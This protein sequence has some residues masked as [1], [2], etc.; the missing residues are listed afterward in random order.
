MQLSAKLSIFF[1]VKKSLLQ[2]FLSHICTPRFYE[3]KVEQWKKFLFW[4][5]L[6]VVLRK[7]HEENK[8]QIF[9]INEKFIKCNFLLDCTWGLVRIN[10]ICYSTGQTWILC[11]ICFQKLQR[12][13]FQGQ[14]ENIW[15][16]IIFL[17]YFCTLLCLSP[18]SITVKVDCNFSSLW[19]IS[20][21]RNFTTIQR[22]FFLFF[23][24]SKDKKKNQTM[25]E[26]DTQNLMLNQI[27][28]CS[29]NTTTSGRRK[30]ISI[31]DGQFYVG[32][33]RKLNRE[34]DKQKHNLKDR[35]WLVF[36]S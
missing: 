29:K 2:R 13:K 33:R 5:D 9:F 35:F 1:F 15:L 16:A 34:A 30:R 36:L 26:T 24:A 18:A 25:N 11:L 22:R 14:F 27:N 21:H 31:V 23:Y 28:L 32:G 12:S 3:L 17:N 20:G 8:L 7:V 10:I 4:R 6:L 19:Y